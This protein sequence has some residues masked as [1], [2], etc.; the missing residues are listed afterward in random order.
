MSMSVYLSTHVRKNVQT[1]QTFLYML[2]VAMTQFS[3]NSAIQYVPFLWMTSCLPITGKA[4]T[5]LIRRILRDSPGVAQILYTAAYRP[6]VY[7]Q[8]DSTGGKNGGNV[9]NGLICI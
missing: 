5:M 6:T 2:P 8:S 1:S 4:K 9:C 7:V 3:D